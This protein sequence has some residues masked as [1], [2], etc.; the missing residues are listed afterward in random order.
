MGRLIDGQWVTEDLGTNAQGK[1]VRRAT[2]FR[3]KIPSEEFPVQAGR[4]RLFVGLACGWSHRVLLLR[5]MKGLEEVIPITVTDAHMGENG[6]TFGD[7]GISGTVLYSNPTDQQKE[8]RIKAMHELYVLAKPDYTGRASVPVLW[9]TTTGTIVNN[10]SSDIVPILA[11]EFDSLATRTSTLTPEGMEES[12][13]EMIQ[14]NYGPINNGVYK[15]GFASSQE[16]YTEAAVALFGR[17]DELEEL[18]GRQRYLIGDQLTLADLCL[19]PTLYRFDEVYY[20]HFKCNRKHLYEYKNL[21]GWAREIYQTAGVKDTCN[22]KQIKEHYYT[23]HESIHPRRYIPLGPDVDFDE[24]H[25]RDTKDY[26]QPPR[27]E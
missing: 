26:R 25:G 4:Y 20:T 24:P 3:N 5:A 18:L 10:E 7:E 16:A 9:D 8:I 22:M 21:W 19:F 2:Q 12:I 1:Y 11:K 23:S 13:P 17:L 6:W 14:T 27:E 15:C